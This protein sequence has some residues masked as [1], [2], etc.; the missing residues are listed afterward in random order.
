MHRD[1]LALKYMVGLFLF[2]VVSC[3]LIK[4]VRDREHRQRINEIKLNG[5]EETIRENKREKRSQRKAAQK[6]LDF[7]TKD[8]MRDAVNELIKE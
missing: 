4:L 6:Q 7:I 1:K 3:G 2:T 8:D 5:L